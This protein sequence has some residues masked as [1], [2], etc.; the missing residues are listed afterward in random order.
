MKKLPIGYDEFREIRE[1][2]FYY[3]D[4]T[5]LIADF[6]AAGD[7]VT[8]IARPRRFGK[9]LNMT[10]IREYFDINVDSKAIF[11]E[12]PTVKDMKPQL[13]LT[14]PVAIQP[15]GLIT[16]NGGARPVKGWRIAVSCGG[17]KRGQRPLLHTTLQSKV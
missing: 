11:Q 17:I 16:R 8:L 5:M 15:G 10:M 12:F 9:T 1:R 13:T 6:L 14:L 4:K 3:V 2:D 7:K